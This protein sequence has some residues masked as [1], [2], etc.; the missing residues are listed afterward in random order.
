MIS[1]NKGPKFATGEVSVVLGIH[2]K[3]S[4]TAD[5]ATCTAAQIEIAGSPLYFAVAL[6]LF[7]VEEHAVFGHVVQCYLW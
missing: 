4:A 1:G 3:S 6:S 2:S 7:A 5:L